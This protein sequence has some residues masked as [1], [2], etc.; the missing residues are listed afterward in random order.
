MPI[1]EFKCTSCGHEKE[2]LIL[3]QSDLK[4]SNK[5]GCDKCKGMY[6]KIMSAPAEPV[7][8]GYNDK[9]SY[10]LKNKN[11]KKKPKKEK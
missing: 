2:I 10:G 4:G 11:D 5:L 7:I 3:K 1:Y 8:H 9:N 6:E